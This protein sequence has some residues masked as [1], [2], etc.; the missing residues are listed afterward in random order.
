MANTEKL[1]HEAKADGAAGQ[2]AIDL[3]RER[4][5]RRALIDQRVVGRPIVSDEE[6]AEIAKEVGTTWKVVKARSAAVQTIR[7]GSNAPD[8]YGVLQ[9]A[10]NLVGK[11]VNIAL[12][13]G[14]IFLLLLGVAAMA[15][16]F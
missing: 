3:E 4:L 13:L 14:L 9:P 7:S 5:A 2:N 10:A 15:Q 12:W 16:M 6:A 8:Q 1:Q 11:S